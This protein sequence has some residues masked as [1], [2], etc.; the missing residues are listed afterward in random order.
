[1]C[2]TLVFWEMGIH[3][4]RARSREAPRRCRTGGASLRHPI[5]LGAERP[6]RAG[7]SS[8]PRWNKPTRRPLRVAGTSLGRMAARKCVGWNAEPAGGLRRSGA[9]R[10][11]NAGWTLLLHGQ[12]DE[13]ER[14]APGTERNPGPPRADQNSDQLPT[15][16]H[17]TRPVTNWIRQNWR[18]WHSKSPRGRGA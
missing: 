8:R 10:G 7:R 2:V 15:Y 14:L 1:M 17:A 18:G 13:G 16:S 5:D 11:A 6:D 3:R 12:P 9:L 4:V